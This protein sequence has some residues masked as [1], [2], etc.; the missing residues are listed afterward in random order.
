MG[1]QQ[2]DACDQGALALVG[3]MH[4]VGQRVCET[5]VLQLAEIMLSA[6][7]RHAVRAI[8]SPMSGVL[9]RWPVRCGSAIHQQE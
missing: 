1:I 4:L 3:L 9:L 8:I 7:R 2:A 6:V 5:A